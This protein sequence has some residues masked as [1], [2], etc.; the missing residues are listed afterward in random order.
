MIRRYLF[1]FSLGFI[2]I[3]T[4]KICVGAEKGLPPVPDPATAL[5]KAQSAALKSDGRTE[6][7]P[8]PES[9]KD[10]YWWVKQDYSTKAEYIKNL[11]TLVK[12]KGVILL[13]PKAGEIIEKLDEAYNPKDNPLDIKM[14]KSIERMFYKITKGMMIK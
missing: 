11:E 4:S 2:L 8:I 12:E 13:E 6:E 9:D 14:D 10:G 5:L 7:I 1:L 3:L